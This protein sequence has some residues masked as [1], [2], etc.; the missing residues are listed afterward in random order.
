MLYGILKTATNTGA[1]NEL[2]SV[3]SAPLTI[4]SNQ[5]SYI[6]DSMNLKRFASSQGIQRWELEANIA[7]SNNSSNFLVHSVLNGSNT[8]I[9]V[10][11]PQVTNLLG[12]QDIVYTAGAFVVGRNYKILTAGTTSFTAI[13]A[14]NNFIGTTFTATGTGATDTQQANN[15]LTFPQEFDN[16]VW[17]LNG[18]G[19]VAANVTSAPDGTPTVD[20]FTRNATASVTWAAFTQAVSVGAGGNVGKTY[21]ASVWLWTSSGTASVNIV[22]SDVGFNT[23]SSSVIT[24]TT[25]PTRY[26]FTTSGGAGWNASGSLIGF[27][28]NAASGNVFN[29]WGAQ[30]QIGAS[31]TTYIPV[32]KGTATIN[33][34]TV[35]STVNA[36]NKTF[37]ITGI[38]SLV[39][40]EFIQFTGDP[41][42]YLVTFGGVTGLN[43]TVEPKLRKNIAA[44]TAIIFCGN[45]I[46]RCRYDADVRLGITY[47]DGV[48]SD[49]GSVKLVEDLQ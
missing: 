46:F 4:T 16:A 10:R 32:V 40:G 13:G 33:T 18:C 24:V 36:G 30:L 23:Y 15:L 37:N 26:T 19:T 17:A 29:A 31:A 6:Q 20:R 43:V 8:V 35:T 27:G 7:P 41:K 47:T 14:A 42:V 12:T 11:M 34:V 5:P 38:P 45:V 2:H 21:T 44:G 25:T 9:Y 1:D 22:V 48:L 3:F 28:L 49:P 39:P